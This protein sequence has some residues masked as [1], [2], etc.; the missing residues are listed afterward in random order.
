LDE[1]AAASGLDANA[2]TA[3]ENL[4][5][6]SSSASRLL[7]GVAELKNV[8]QLV[9]IAATAAAEPPLAGELEPLAVELEP[10]AGVAAADDEGAVV[11]GEAEL[12]PLLEQA[13][14][15][16]ARARPSAGAR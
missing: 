10:P 13:A 4:S 14:N 8:T 3:A 12:E 7:F 11:V 15:V 1:T 2:D 6:F 5:P 9:L 16:A